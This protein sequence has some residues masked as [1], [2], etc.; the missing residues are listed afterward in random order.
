MRSDL[1]D[2]NPIRGWTVRELARYLRI[3]PDRVRAMIRR[4][5]LGAVSTAP[6]RSGRPRFIVL[7]HHLLEWER[8]HQAATTHTPATRRRRRRTQPIDYYPDGGTA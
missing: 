6:T 2:T 7:P 1:L 5:E 3:G 8:R 4:G